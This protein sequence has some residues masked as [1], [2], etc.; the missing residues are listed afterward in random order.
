[1]IISFLP[2]QVNCKYTFRLHIVDVHNTLALLKAAIV[3]MTGIS[4]K[5]AV[6]ADGVF[7]EFNYMYYLS[8]AVMMDIW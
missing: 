1:M 2:V 5:N 7:F 6:P 3:H 4:R 8:A